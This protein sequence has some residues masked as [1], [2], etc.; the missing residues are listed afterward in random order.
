M[1]FEIAVVKDIVLDDTSKYFTTA[2]EWNGIGTVFFQKV[3][4]RNYKSTGFAKPFFSNLSN[5]PLLEELIYIFKLPSPDIQKNNLQDSYY[6]LTPINIW[7]S[8]HH[9]G[10]PNLF[11]ANLP[12]SQ[13][14]DYEQ[15]SLGA[16]RRVQ[17][18]SSDIKLG[19]SFVERSYIKPLKRFEG[20]VIVEGRLGNS[21]RLGSTN[22]IDN[23]A[24][25]NWSQ[26]GTTGDP[27]L[28][29]R[30][31][32]GDTGSVGYIPTEENINSDPSSIYL[33]TSQ[34]I[35][36]TVASTNNYLSYKSDKPQAPNIYKN[37][38]VIITSGRVLLNSQTDHILLTSAKSINL[39]ARESVNFDTTGDIT[40]QSNKVYLGGKLA[41]EPV[42]LGNTAVKEL[43]EIVEILKELLIAGTQAAN[44]GGPILPLQSKSAEL[45]TRLQ[46]IN[47]DLMKSSRTFTI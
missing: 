16:V 31:G 10:I 11:A 47:L 34:I 27:I 20:D 25:N 38:Q 39:N 8:N 37:N 22:L 4:G 13:K 29:L 41:E 18:R 9:N 23:N 35:P 42:L 3:K 46:S 5:Y 6:Y 7:N 45:L 12:D 40:L 17:D 44:S 21:I 24:L 14:R 19:N 33:T 1:E 2:G 30:N 15:T 32:Q 36:I 28:I 26:N 43:K